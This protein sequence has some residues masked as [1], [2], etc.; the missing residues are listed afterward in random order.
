M[1]DKTGKNLRIVGIVLMALTTAMN[2][3][4]GTGTV[5]AA[6][7]TKKYPMV[8]ILRPVDYRWLY[9]TF[10]IVTI[11]IG[12]VG[13]WATIN[14]V[15]GKSR[16][17]QNA[18]IVLAVGT[19][20]S[21]IHFY[22]SMSIRGSA[23]PANMKFFANGITL[24][25]FLIFGLPGVRQRVNFSDPGDTNTQMTSGG[26][27]AIMVG[28][29]TLSIRSWVGASHI[30]EGNNWVDVLKMPLLLTGSVM[31]VSGLVLMLRVAREKLNVFS[32]ERE[33]TVSSK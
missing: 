6:F 9:Q 16:A 31:I 21:G 32:G 25:V 15:R 24:L 27:A 1:E 17:Y 7:L 13:I 10:M 23:T 8:D 4:G 26:L 19:L 30:Y 20:V 28:I 29:L 3:L 5:C 12:L 2:I 18:V 11:L 14:L 22:A 33:M